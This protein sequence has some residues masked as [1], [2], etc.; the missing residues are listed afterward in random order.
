MVVINSVPNRAAGVQPL[1]PHGTGL[2]CTCPLPTAT[3]LPSE[4]GVNGGG[5]RQQVPA[6]GHRLRDTWLQR[7]G[8]CSW[9][10]G[11]VG[12]PVVRYSA[13]S[14][15][16]PSTPPV[17]V[18]A[19]NDGPVVVGVYAMRNVRA[20][21]PRVLRP[22]LW[23]NSRLWRAYPVAAGAPLFVVKPPIKMR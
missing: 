20:Y 5:S 12:R 13:G 4:G 3:G 15:L 7:L 23:D 19:T 2:A 21:N 17:P 16:G 14:N 9:M 10:G 18:P 1:S 6:T 22:N 11:G 8:T